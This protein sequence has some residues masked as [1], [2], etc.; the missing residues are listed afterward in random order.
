MQTKPFINRTPKKFAQTHS[1]CIS[2]HAV[3]KFP[4]SCP[5]FQKI[6]SFFIETFW[7]ILHTS[8]LRLRGKILLQKH[9]F[10]L[11]FT[12]GNCFSM[13]RQTIYL[14]RKNTVQ[15]TPMYSN[16]ENL[17]SEIS[18]GRTNRYAI[19]EVK[20]QYLRWRFTRGY[21]WRQFHKPPG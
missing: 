5:I 3:R 6:F 9:N 16:I 18:L 7:N 4:L 8:V 19:T 14:R 12:A 17:N 15:R 13:S 2:R 10:L 11:S 20:Q 1:T 21:C